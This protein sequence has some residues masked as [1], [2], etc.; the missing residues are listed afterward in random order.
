MRELQLGEKMK[1]YDGAASQG[2]SAAPF[3]I[4]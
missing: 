4:H 3:T 2:H 1:N